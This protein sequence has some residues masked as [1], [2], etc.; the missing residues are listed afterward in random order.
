MKQTRSSIAQLSRQGIGWAS[1][2]TETC[3]PPFRSVLLPTYPVWTPTP[4]PS[5][6]GGR[7]A[8]CRRRSVAI[9]NRPALE[10]EGKK[11]CGTRSYI[12]D[13]IRKGDGLTCPNLI[14]DLQ[15]QLAR[16]LD[17]LLDGLLRRQHL[18]QL[19]LVVGIPHGLS[20]P[21]GVAMGK[22]AN[23]IDPGRTQ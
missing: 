8:R 23:G 13:S 17:Q 10:G 20:Q 6:Q 22:F 21:G 9:C 3:H 14:A 2:P 5:P 1:Q 7:G 16:F 15:R 4:N 18:D 11:R 12:C 19:A